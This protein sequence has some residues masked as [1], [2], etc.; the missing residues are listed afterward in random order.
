MSKEDRGTW[1]YRFPQSISIKIFDIYESSIEPIHIDHVPDNVDLGDIFSRQNGLW[2]D[3]TLRAKNENFERA[4]FVRKFKDW[5]GVWIETSLN[6]LGIPNEVNFIS[7]PTSL[8]HVELGDR[9]VTQ[10]NEVRSE[11]DIVVAITP[12]SIDVDNIVF[13]EWEQNKPRPIWAL[14]VAKR[15]R[16]VIGNVCV[17]RGYVTKEQHES[18]FSER[19]LES[20]ISHGLQ[21]FNEW[22]QSYSSPPSDASLA[23]FIAPKFEIPQKIEAK[24]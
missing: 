8:S 10:I 18:I 1:R 4:N 22:G 24:Q 11:F 13:I 17:T 6:Q 12:T 16:E 20:S 19:T 14:S 7:I 3:V 23:W 15:I 21:Y 9:T 2:Y 5:L